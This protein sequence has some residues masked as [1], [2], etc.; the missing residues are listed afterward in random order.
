VKTIENSAYRGFAGGFLLSD[1]HFALADRCS[2]YL[3]LFDDTVITKLARLRAG[4]G[5]IESLRLAVQRMREY[6]A[7]VE[8]ECIRL[9][10]PSRRPDKQG[11]VKIIAQQKLL[12]TIFEECVAQFEAGQKACDVNDRIRRLLREADTSVDRVPDPPASEKMLEGR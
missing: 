3:E 6:S 8:I 9:A 11:Y 12:T 2:T 5:D 10:A 4:S 1:R 7:G